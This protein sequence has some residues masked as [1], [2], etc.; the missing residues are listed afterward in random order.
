MAVS[1]EVYPEMRI[2]ASQVADE[3]LSVT[4][5]KAS[6]V[7]FEEDGSVF[8]SARSLGD[9]NV[10]WIMERLGGGGHFTMAAAQLTETH[11]PEVIEQLKTFIDEYLEME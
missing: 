4:G 3:L 7:L 1:T 6:Y 10:Q 2:I 11:V 8:V 5:V 9:M